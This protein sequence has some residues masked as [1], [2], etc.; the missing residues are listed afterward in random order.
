MASLCKPVYKGG[1]S[2]IGWAKNKEIV[3]AALSHLH[4][5]I[6]LAKGCTTSKITMR[7]SPTMRCSRE[8]EIKVPGV[9]SIT[10]CQWYLV[11]R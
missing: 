4:I 3:Q 11:S 8:E 7:P 5:F 9:P 6:V 10:H 2:G 1:I